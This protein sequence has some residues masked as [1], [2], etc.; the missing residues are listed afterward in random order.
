MLEKK[1][2]VTKSYT[3]LNDQ[4]EINNNDQQ[5]KD[6]TTSSICNNELNTKSPKIPTKIPVD[7]RGILLE[8]HYNNEID[9]KNKNKEVKENS[10]KNK[11]KIKKELSDN[12]TVLFVG[13]KFVGKS[14]LI[15]RLL[16]KNFEETYDESIIDSY[17]CERF[18]ILED[19]IKTNRKEE[20]NEIHKNKSISNFDENQENK[21]NPLLTI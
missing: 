1:T 16:N 5:N 9:N 11:E 12:Y 8:Q 17:A 10:K 3:N 13:E 21:E 2:E 7:V 4:N 15:N 6:N 14:S 18:Y 19:N 20:L